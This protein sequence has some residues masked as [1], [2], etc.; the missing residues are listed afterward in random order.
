[1]AKYGFSKFVYSS[2]TTITLSL[3]TFSY[4]SYNSYIKSIKP[5]NFELAANRLVFNDYKKEEIYVSL[6]EH[7]EALLK[8]LQMLEYFQPE[9]LWQDVNHLGVKNPKIVFKH[10]YHVIKKSNADQS[11]PNKFKSKILDS[12][13]KVI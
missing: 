11:D 13:L 1:M 8:Q 9:K 4:F 6:F 3:I 12:V 10:L 7:Q 2:F 5:S